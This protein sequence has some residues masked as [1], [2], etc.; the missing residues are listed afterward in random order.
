MKPLDPPLYCGAGKS[1]NF[2]PNCDPHQFISR[3]HHFLS[4]FIYNS[5]MTGIFFNFTFELLRYAQDTATDQASHHPGFNQ[6]GACQ[7]DVPISPDPF[8]PVVKHP[9]TTIK[10]HSKVPSRPFWPAESNRNIYLP[11][12]LLVPAV[13]TKHL[14]ISDFHWVK[15]HR[16][17]STTHNP[18]FH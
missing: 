18:V 3:I 6:V 15:F 2:S 16:T 11:L 5:P 9:S 7:H 1:M 13:A 8:Y 17:T 4:I 12:P 14:Q 10:T